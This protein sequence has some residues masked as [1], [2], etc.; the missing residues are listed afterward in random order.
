MASKTVCFY[1]CLISHRVPH[2]EAEITSHC[3]GFEPSKFPREAEQRMGPCLCPSYHLS[4]APSPALWSSQASLFLP[5]TRFLPPSGLFH[6]LGTLFPFSPGLCIFVSLLSLRFYLGGHDIPSEKPVLGP[7]QLKSSLL[8]SIT[9]FWFLFSSHSSL[10]KIIYYAN[11]KS[12]EKW[13]THISPWT[14]CWDVNTHA[15][16]TF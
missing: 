11:T 4:Q 8:N 1:Y 16:F 13:N 2:F 14:D 9:F 6:L 7:G 5:A 3:S 12:G 15:V 10:L